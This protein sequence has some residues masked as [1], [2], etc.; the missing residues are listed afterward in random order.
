M[1]WID[2]LGLTRTDAEER[3]V[4]QVDAVEQ[5]G[6]ADV[7]LAG[8]LGVRV[9]EGAGLPSGV[10]DGG[11]GISA[12]L[13]EVPEGVEVADVAGSA[14]RKPDDRDGLVAEASRGDGGSGGRVDTGSAVTE[15][16]CERIAE[17]FG[18]ALSGGV[19]EG[20]GGR[21]LER[22]GFLEPA[23]EL[24]GHEGIEAEVDKT[25]V[26]LDAGWVGLAED[27]GRLGQDE[28]DKELEAEGLGERAEL[29]KEVSLWSFGAEWFAQRVEGAACVG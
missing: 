15:R 1:L 18:D 11:D 7:A 8:G 10:W 9:V 4:E 6:I 16:G 28:R 17:E 12:L 21:Q 29:G 25:L 26:E 3:R 22:S 23:T 13:E 2:V 27:G 19:I 5:G 20:D 14:E 24:D